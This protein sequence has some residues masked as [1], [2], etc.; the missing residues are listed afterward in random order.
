MAAFCRFRFRPG[1]G[2]RRGLLQLLQ[3]GFRRRRVL[4]INRGGYSH[5]RRLLH[6]LLI[7]CGLR[8]VPIN[9]IE[10]VAAEEA[11]TEFVPWFDR[12]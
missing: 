10:N 9:L 8:V 12:V 2:L 6:L 5:D 4:S 11:T 3:I 7:G 1:I